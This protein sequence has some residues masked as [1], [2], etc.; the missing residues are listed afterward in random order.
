MNGLLENAEDMPKD[1]CTLANE[2]S[3]VA[4][5]Y[6][7]YSINGYNFHT[8]SYD[9]G[10][11]VQSSGVALV[12]KTSSFSNS[13]DQNPQIGDVTYYGVITKI[14]ELDYHRMGNI[15]LFKCDWVDVHQKDKWV[16]V[17]NLETR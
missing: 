9:E 2:Y 7:S 14:L 8:K 15:V 11:S 3:M 1:I 12:T 5:K 10:R 6:N 16:K 13:K 4:T 17:T